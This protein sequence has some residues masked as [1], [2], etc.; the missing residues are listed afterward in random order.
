MITN[1][2]RYFNFDSSQRKDGSDNAAIFQMPLLDSDINFCSVSQVRVPKIYNVTTQLD[3]YGIPMNQITIDFSAAYTYPA[4]VQAN[5]GAVPI[6]LTIP[7]GTYSGSSLCIEL[8]RVVYNYFWNV[9]VIPPGFYFPLLVFDTIKPYKDIAT[10]TSG[11][12]SFNIWMFARYFFNQTKVIQDGSTIGGATIVNLKLTFSQKLL[13]IL[14]FNSSSASNYSTDGLS[15]FSGNTISLRFNNQITYANPTYQITTEPYNPAPYT[16]FP[17][18]H[19]TNAGVVGYNGYYFQSNLASNLN[20]YS[21]IFVEC[22]STQFITN[23]NIPGYPSNQIISVVDTSS[24]GFPYVSSETDTLLINMNRM[25]NKG[26]GNVEFRYY[27]SD[28]NLINTYGVPT[29][30]RLSFYNYA[31][32]KKADEIKLIPMI[33]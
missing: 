9:L 15:S 3:K 1:Q 30:I 8:T 24:S 21:Q 22:R 28:Y 32:L 26:S 11:Y 27:D 2:I 23:N 29:S 5:T 17:D 4:G 31:E 19:P 14:G 10:G 7:V 33:K 18:P 16:A 12:N 25:D 20:Y 6:N 13:N